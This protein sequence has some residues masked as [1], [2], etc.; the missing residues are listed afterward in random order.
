MSKMDKIV[1]GFG[2]LNI[3]ALCFLFNAGLEERSQEMA[4]KM[5]KKEAAYYECVKAFK[6]ESYCFKFLFA[7][8]RG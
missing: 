8:W 2:I 5:E 7:D 1:L 4:D 3:F 6:D